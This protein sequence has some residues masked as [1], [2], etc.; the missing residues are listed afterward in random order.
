MSGA[1]TLEI[2]KRITL[3]ETWPPHTHL[4]THV[5]DRT[6]A[7]ID[8]AMAVFHPAPRSFTGEDV[9]EISCHGNPLV[10]DRILAL[11]ATTR[12][13][14]Q[15][16]K[17]EFTKRAFLNR[18]IDLAQAEAVGAMIR[19]GSGAGIEM[20]T[21]LLDGDLSRTVHEIEHDLL[22]ITTRIE[23][24]FIMEDVDVSGDA[25]LEAVGHALNRLDSLLEGSDVSPA[26]FGGIATTIAGLPNAG[27][28]SLFNAILGYPRSIVHDEGGTTRD[29]IREQVTIDGIDFIFHDTAGIRNTSSGPEQIGVQRTIEQLSQSDLVLYV[30]DARKGLQPEEQPWLDL[31]KK[32]V[33]VMNKM[34][35]LDGQTRDNP[36]ER[37]VWV[38]AK[39]QSGIEELMNVMVDTYPR[40]IPKIFI[41]RHACL[42]E[43]ARGSLLQARQSALDS[44]TADVI[45]IDLNH[46]VEALRQIIGK[47]ADA[48]IL[49]KIFS[50]FCVGK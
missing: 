15:A 22:A 20:A 45:T 43:K 46:A 5:R 33:V 50:Q 40:I 38:S 27:K 39:Y 28:S 12:L 41:Q 48:D 23:A 49:E 16:Q 35:L 25:I 21:A 44:V 9:A 2:L 31:G 13:A 47:E 14:R 29:I 24:S 19:A 7:V 6:G 18:K 36:R 30:V 17:G 4:F 37:T 26:V 11:I 10:V 42:L 34:D 3:Q 32:T 1:E 8:Q